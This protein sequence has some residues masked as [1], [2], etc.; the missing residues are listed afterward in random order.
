MYRYGHHAVQM[1][2]LISKILDFETL[3]IRIVSA[4]DIIVPALMWSADTTKDTLSSETCSMY[5][6][7]LLSTRMRV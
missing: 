5:R 2:L 3:I 1:M 6:W 7:V 4:S